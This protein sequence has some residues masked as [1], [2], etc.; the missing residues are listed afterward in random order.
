MGKEVSTGT[1]K[2]ALPAGPHTAPAPD[3]QHPGLESHRQQ[4]S[5]TVALPEPLGLEPAQSTQEQSCQR[6]QTT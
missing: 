4:G 1:F 2:N 6:Q 3:L 5:S